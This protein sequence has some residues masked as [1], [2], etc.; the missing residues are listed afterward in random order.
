M[1]TSRCRDA[2][3]L[4]G[5]SYAGKAIPLPL[6]L[7][8]VMLLVPLG[9]SSSPAISEGHR[10]AHVT[11]VDSLDLRMPRASLRIKHTCRQILEA[12]APRTGRLRVREADRLGPTRLHL[13]PPCI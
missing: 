7:L 8:V 12:P 4:L 3:R 6:T 2:C 5:M 1:L 11:M 9:T 10:P 13:P